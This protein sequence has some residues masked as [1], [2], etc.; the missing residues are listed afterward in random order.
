MKIPVHVVT[1]PPRSGKSALIERLVRARSDWL[2]LAGAVPAGAA[3]NLKLLSGGCP[4]CTGRV[5]LQVSLARWLRETG[6][7]RAFVE[8]P[9]S[10]HAAMLGKLFGEPP[11]GRSIA[12]ARPIVLPGEALLA[13]SD[14]ESQRL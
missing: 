11:L 2:G 7:T 6:A 13:A 5:V 8:M 14:L 1:G 3:A 12:E 4:C 9:D 10:Q